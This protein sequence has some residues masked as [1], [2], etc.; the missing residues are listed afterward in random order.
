MRIK[1]NCNN[2]T[3]YGANEIPYHKI[4]IQLKSILMLIDLR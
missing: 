4:D 3:I 1:K 2:I